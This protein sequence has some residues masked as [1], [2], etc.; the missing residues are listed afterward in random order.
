MSGL[1]VTLTPGEF[2][3][4]LRAGGLTPALAPPGSPPGALPPALAKVLGQIAVSDIRTRFQTG[5]APDGA[6]WRPLKHPRPTGGNQP[7]LDTGVLRASIHAVP[8]P[9]GVTVQTT[10]PAAPLHQ[11]GGVVRPRRAKMLAI[12]LTKEAR[13]SGG[14]RRFGKKLALRPTRKPRVYLLVAEAR[15]KVTAHFVLVRS[16]TVPARPFMGLSAAGLETA[17]RAIAEFAG[18][19]WAAGR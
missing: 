1:A 18:A 15:G 8:D 2:A 6:K 16:V 17:A 12:P 7:L 10:H 14:P 19:A 4:R 3:R 9:A 13:R 5:T 11:F